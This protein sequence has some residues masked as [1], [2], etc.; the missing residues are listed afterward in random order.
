M[1][2]IN[3]VHTSTSPIAPYKYTPQISLPYPCHSMPFPLPPY[4]ASTPSP[5]PTRPRRQPK[6]RKLAQPKRPPLNLPS[7]SSPTRLRIPDHKNHLF[8]VHPNPT[9]R[10]QRV[11]QTCDQ[12]GREHGRL[13]LEVVG[14][15]A[16]GA[17]E[18]VGW[19]ASLVGKGKKKGGGRT[20]LVVFGLLL[21]RVAG[22]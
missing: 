2:A 11:A 5:S 22:G 10:Q 8:S 17:V 4:P 1:Y 15:R 16:L 7:H 12:Q 19:G 3:A 14:V 20:V 9:R 21:R 13:V 6:Q 18:E